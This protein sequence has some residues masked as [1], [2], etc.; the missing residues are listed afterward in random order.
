MN[1]GLQNFLGAV[2]RLNK[3]HG[4][5]QLVADVKPLPARYSSRQRSPASV[6]EGRLSNNAGRDNLLVEYFQN[7]GIG[8]QGSFA[9]SADHS[10]D[11]DIDELSWLDTHPDD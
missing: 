10:S 2:E 7:T 8:M 4:N 11:L 3:Y 1:S 6:P 5:S 9:F